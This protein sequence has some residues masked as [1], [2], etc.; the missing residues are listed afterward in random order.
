[1]RSVSRAGQKVTTLP[2]VAEAETST[3]AVH[4]YDNA[5]APRRGCRIA[6]DRL[7]LLRHSGPFLEIGLCPHHNHGAG[8]MVDHFVTD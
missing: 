1:M 5:K 3:S 4:P 2:S 6:V 8:G 7:R